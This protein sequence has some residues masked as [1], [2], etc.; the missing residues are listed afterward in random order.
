MAAPDKSEDLEAASTK[1]EKGPEAKAVS[2]SRLPGIMLEIVF[3]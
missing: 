1:D 2:K 3:R